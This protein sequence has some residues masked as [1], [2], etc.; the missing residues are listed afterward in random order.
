MSEPQDDYYTQQAANGL[1]ENGYFALASLLEAN[2][3]SLNYDIGGADFSTESMVQIAVES[4][5][6]NYRDS[7]ESS[8]SSFSDR[9]SSWFS[10]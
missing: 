4:T 10:S 3:P 5:F 9:I 7:I 1:R 6:D 8:V 2:D